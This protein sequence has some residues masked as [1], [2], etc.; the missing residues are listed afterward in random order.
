VSSLN[1]S[2]KLMLAE[3]LECIKDNASFSVASVCRPSGSMFCLT[4]QRVTRKTYLTVPLKQKGAWGITAILLRIWISALF[5]IAKGAKG[6][7]Y[8][9]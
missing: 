7:Q 9:M 1:F 5:A 6:R 8:R 3:V 4:G 2:R